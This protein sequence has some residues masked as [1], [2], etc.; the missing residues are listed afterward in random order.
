MN[1]N[2]KVNYY[3]TLLLTKKLQHKPYTDGYD[4]TTLSKLTAAIKQ[5]L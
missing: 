3:R 5:P 4:K 1:L 2:V